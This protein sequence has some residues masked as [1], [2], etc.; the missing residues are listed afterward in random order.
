MKSKNTTP[1]CTMSLDEYIVYDNINV[2]E[3][4]DVFDY[5]KE[6]EPLKTDNPILKCVDSQM[7][8]DDLFDC[9]LPDTSPV[10]YVSKKLNSIDNNLNIHFLNEKYYIKH[11][12][13]YCP[14]CYS[15]NVIKD[16]DRN[17]P[18]ILDKLGKVDCVIKK[19]KCK[20]CGKKFSTDISSIVRSKANISNDILE[21]VRRYY[22]IFSTS[23]RKIKEGLTVLNNVNISHQE[24]QDI[25]LGYSE[26]YVSKLDEYSGYYAFDS[27]WVK[28]NE[29]SDKYV[30]LLVL[31]DVRHKT[32]VSYRLVEKE[33]EDVIY[34]FLREATRNQPRI[35]ITTD[36]KVEYRRPI[37][38]L[39]FKHQFCIFH[40]KQNIQRSI[41]D[42][43]KKNKLPEEKIDEYYSYLK[44]IYKIFHAESRLEVSEIVKNLL[45]R[46]D[47]FPEIINEIIKDKIQ[48]YAAYLTRYLE[49]SLIEKTSNMI[50]GI[51]AGTFPKSIKNNYLTVDGF[52]SRFNIKFERWERRNAIF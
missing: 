50:E 29:M 32:I 17:K 41:R 45:E 34:D 2:D 30:F 1:N 31:V 46:S 36:L 24:I 9:D 37:D 19:Y 23:L 48:P 15:K 12:R 18:V 11:F 42:Y 33:T 49:D 10:N 4:S 26:E 38:K 51:F 5:E 14:E 40:A 16:G 47:E 52:L 22:S 28:V 39:G 44:E 8:L 3:Y 20:S 43:V 35:A 27:L 7:F 13:V 25:I 6:A 21:M